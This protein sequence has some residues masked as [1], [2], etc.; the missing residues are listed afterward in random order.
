[1]ELGTYLGGKTVLLRYDDANGGWFRV[2]PRAA[3]VPGD[4]LFALPEFRPKIS[5]A[6]GVHFGYLG[7][8]AGGDADSGEL[9]RPTA[10]RRLMPMCRRSKWFMG[11]L[12]W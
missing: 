6:S 4:R 1:M 7:R 3:M 9:N 5:L 12:F 10:C 2:Q 8:H 11:G